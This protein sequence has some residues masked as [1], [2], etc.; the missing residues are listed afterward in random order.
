MG[1]TLSFYY[2]YLGGVVVNYCFLVTAINTRYIFF[3]FGF[4]I[5]V[6]EVYITKLCFQKRKKKVSSN[7]SSSYKSLI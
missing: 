3:S 1:Y 7:R 6:R 4:K 5:P 2:N